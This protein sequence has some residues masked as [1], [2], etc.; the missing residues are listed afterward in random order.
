MDKCLLL[1]RKRCHHL[2]T[3]AYFKNV[4][5]ATLYIVITYR[6]TQINISYVA[7][8]ITILLRLSELCVDRYFIFDKQLINNYNLPLNR[9]KTLA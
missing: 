6:H 7:N 3:H 9:K 4:L 5:L 1:I 8:T 2:V